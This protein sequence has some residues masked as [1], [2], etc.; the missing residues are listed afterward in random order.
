MSKGARLFLTWWK[1]KKVATAPRQERVRDLPKAFATMSTKKKRKARENLSQPTNRG[2][3]GG[4]FLIGGEKKGG[5]NIFRRDI[6]E[7]GSFPGV[8]FSNYF[9]GEEDPSFGG[10]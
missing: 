6:L 10:V 3:T 5:V 7:K 2:E 9:G 1:K 8:V 4:Y